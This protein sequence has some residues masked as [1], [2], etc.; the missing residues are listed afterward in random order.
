LRFRRGTTLTMSPAHLFPQFLSLVLAI[1]CVVVHG[2]TLNGVGP[3]LLAV[4]GGFWE[5][6]MQWLRHRNW[7]RHRDSGFVPGTQHLAL[8]A[9][10]GWF[11]GVVAAA[12][13]VFRA[14]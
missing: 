9:A 10:V 4:A 11:L 14:T 12:V 13:W 7:L 5:F 6:W 8:S 2:W 3:A 1:L